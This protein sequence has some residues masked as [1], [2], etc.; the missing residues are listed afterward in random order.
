MDCGQLCIETFNDYVVK[1][2]SSW[3]NCIIVPMNN[4]I[5]LPLGKYFF[6]DTYNWSM[7]I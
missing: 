5:S 2:I 4:G 3:H 1:S 6:K 7:F